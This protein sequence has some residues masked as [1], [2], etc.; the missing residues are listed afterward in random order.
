MLSDAYL[1]FRLFDLGV[2]FPY[3][4][5]QTVDLVL[6]GLLSFFVN[7]RVRHITATNQGLRIHGHIHVCVLLLDLFLREIVVQLPQTQVLRRLFLYALFVPDFENS[8]Q[9]EIKVK[10]L[11]FPCFQA[12]DCM[13]NLLSLIFCEKEDF[14]C[15]FDEFFA[16]RPKF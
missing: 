7:V 16:F 6:K 12:Y 15:T 10:K 13:I 4:I 2:F 1:A 8:I 3:L 9:S 14:V 5:F 11:R